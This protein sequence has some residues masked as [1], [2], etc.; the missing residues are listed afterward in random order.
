MH[1]INWT[2]KSSYT[3]GAELEVRIHDPDSFNLKEYSSQILPLLSKSL[4]PHVHQEFLECMLE[5]VTPVCDSADEVI[6]HIQSC[7]KEVNTLAYEHN[8]TLATSGSHAFVVDHLKHIPKQRYE[9][10][11]Q[12]FGVI[13]RRFHICGFHIHVGFKTGD[14]AL[15][16]YNY[17][18]AQ[19]PLFL[20]LSANS[21]YFYG[22]DTGLESYRVKMFDQLS[23]AGIPNYFENFDEIQNTY[24]IL[25]EAGT[26][27]TYNDIWWDL[28]ISPKFGTLEIRI[29]DASNDFDRLKALIHLYQAMA[30]LSGEDSREQLP[31]QV[32]KQNK[33]NAA[34]HGLDGKFHDLDGS[35]SM[36]EYL[37]KQIIKME[38]RQIFQR[39]DIKLC[40]VKKL[41]SFLHVP[42]LSTKQ[43]EIYA[44]TKSLMEVEKYGRLL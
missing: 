8:F 16:A 25:A 40:D 10:I 42:S 6:E 32:L 11:A 15:R 30:L 17:I 29:C 26:I 43:R 1:F 33:W 20:A 36:R 19:L 23:R 28:R 37:E 44:Q 3:L 39:L 5:F 35:M 31:Y 21:P 12:E 34:R 4:K 24:S 14:E 13:L 9:L 18:L 38:E 41:K 22:E 27:T 7:I 2:D